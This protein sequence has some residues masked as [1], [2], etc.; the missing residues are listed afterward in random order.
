M[1]AYL[2]STLKE[3]GS[4]GN[5]KCISSV[6]LWKAF[7]QISLNPDTREKTVGRDHFFFIV[8]T[9]IR[10]HVLQT[11]QR[12]RHANSFQKFDELGLNNVFVYQNN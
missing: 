12:L 7:R 11:Y 8:Y 3:F 4:L 10:C 6:G 1:T 9:F 2:Y 5:A